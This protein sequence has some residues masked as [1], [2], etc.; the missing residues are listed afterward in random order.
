MIRKT[1]LPDGK[2]VRVTFELPSSIWAESIYLVGEFNQWSKASLP[3]RQERDG[4]WEVTLDLPR[5]R[6][7][8][9]LYLVNG[10][11]WQNDSNAD[12]YVPNDFGASNSMV[13][14]E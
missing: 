3:L 8:Q 7:Y 10:T 9:F 6:R 11:Q 2:E 14:T 1:E 5:G 13:S 12:G 4:T